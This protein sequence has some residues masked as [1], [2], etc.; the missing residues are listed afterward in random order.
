[1]LKPPPLFKHQKISLKLL[2]IEN[3]VFDMSDAGTGKT[4]VHAEDFARKREAGGGCGLVFAPR[5]ILQ[6]AWGNDIEKYAGHLKYNIARAENR[7]DAFEDSADIYITNLDAATW[8][9]QQKPSFFKRFSHLIIDESTAYKHHT[10][11]RSKAIAKITKYFPVRRNLSGTPHPNGMCD[12]WHQVKLLDDGKRLGSSFFHFRS[13][14]CVPEQTGP[15]ANHLKWVD[16]EGAELAVMG[17]LKD[18][19]LRHVLEECLDM[20]ENIVYPMKYRL[21]N[22]QLAYYLKLEQDSILKIKD[23]KI[24]AVNGAVLYSKLL[25][26]ASG[27]VYDENQDYVV[28]DTGRYELVGDLVEQRVHSIVMFQ[29]AHQLD[30]L[31]AE[32][33]K[34]G[35]SFAVIDGNTSDKERNLITEYFQKGFYRAILAHPKSAAHGFTWTRGTATIW[36]SP[37]INL[38]WWLQGNRRIYRAGQT[39]RTETIVILAEG[40][41][42]ESVYNSLLIKDVNMSALLKGLVT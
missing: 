8:L 41:R 27:A 42:D 22:K 36:P 10:S 7:K 12:I 15:S 5:S 40:T 33:E 17:L 32:F 4:R 29:W 3:R 25:Q 39:Q 9:A 21:S 23:Q 35:L 1:M 24:T 2:G 30:M 14:V 16:R 20:P 34:R 28:L 11:G 13:S 18:I 19:T 38:E 37:T 31:C 26:A 6:S